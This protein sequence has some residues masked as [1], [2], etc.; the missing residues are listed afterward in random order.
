MV[1]AEQNKQ[2]KKNQIKSPS[3]LGRQ[4]EVYDAELFGIIGILPSAEKKM[5]I[6]HRIP[7]GQDIVAL[8]GQSGCGATGCFAEG[9][10]K[11]EH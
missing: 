10:P 6:N 2:K 9:R 11:P 8:H 3:R 1:I 7:T 5:P 4:M